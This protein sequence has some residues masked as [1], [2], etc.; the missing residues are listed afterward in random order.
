VDREAKKQKL[1]D[2]LQ[3]L[4][5]DEDHIDDLV[6]E[7]TDLSKEGIKWMALAR[8]RTTNFFSPQIF[9]QHMCVAWS[10]TMEVKITAL[11]HN[12]FTI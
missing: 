10:P 6:F 2:M 5:I 3:R 4:G 9:E 12:L 7:E 8:F 11:E 1:D